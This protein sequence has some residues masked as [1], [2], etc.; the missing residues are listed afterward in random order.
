MTVHYSCG[1]TLCVPCR[2]YTLCGQAL[3]T[4]AADLARFAL[5]QK[6]ERNVS[7]PASHPDNRG[8]DGHFGPCWWPRRMLG[9]RHGV[10]SRRDQHYY[11]RARHNALRRPRCTLL[12]HRLL[13]RH[14]H[15][16]DPF[17]CRRRPPTPTH[18][19]DKAPTFG[20]EK[21]TRRRFN[22]SCAIHSSLAI[23]G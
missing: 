10:A 7:A 12:R 18:A 17:P 8:C 9:Y 15:T 3:R 21:P 16:S 19:F 2:C 23:C 4:D 6:R 20:S 14:L 22:Q 11:P 5:F 1:S 13:H